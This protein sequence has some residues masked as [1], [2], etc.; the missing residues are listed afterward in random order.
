[1]STAAKI[2]RATQLAREKKE[3]ELLAKAKEAGFFATDGMYFLYFLCLFFL[4]CIF[5][6]VCF[7][8]NR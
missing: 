2:A 4:V 3:Q 5:I 8:C 7:F 1:M 6:C